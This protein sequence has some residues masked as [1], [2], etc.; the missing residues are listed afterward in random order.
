MLSLRPRR[1]FV[2]RITNGTMPT[3]FH[4]PAAKPFWVLYIILAVLA[5][6]LALPPAWHPLPS[7][8]AFF[9]REK[10]R[11]V[12]IPDAADVQSGIVQT[13]RKLASPVADPASTA[14]KKRH[15]CESKPFLRQGF[16]T[17]PCISKNRHA[18]ERFASAVSRLQTQGGLVRIG[19]FTDSIG[20]GDKITSTLREQFQRRFGDGGPGYV[21]V[22]PLR[23]WHY[24]SRVQLLLS[25]GWTPYCFIGH[26][27]SDRRYGFG[28]IGIGHRGTG[29][30]VRLR[31]KDGGTFRAAQIHFLHHPEGGIF[32]IKAGG[33]TVR[34]IDTRGEKYKEGYVRVSFDSAS[35]LELE[36][37]SGGLVR[38]NAVFLENPGPGVVLDAVS[39]TGARFENWYLMP[40]GHLQAEMAARAPDLLLFH[41]GLNESDTDVEADYKDRVAG[42]MQLVQKAAPASCIIV[43]PSDKV[44]KHNGQ[45]RTLP[46]IRKIA[47]LQEQAAFQA[48]CAFFDTLEAMGGETA[49]VK[50]YE[51]NPRLAMGDLTHITSE[52]AQLLGN[53]MYRDILA[54]LVEP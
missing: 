43:G 3:G 41:F 13:E 36:T 11:P 1:V 25:Q 50:W 7:W 14:T 35:V 28:G 4:F 51:H 9:I 30:T 32:R 34:D 21:S 47:Q 38:I 12:Q 52:G 40:Q 44:Q 6:S 39:L 17:V 19:Y 54:V 20:S 10:A 23:P 31:A 8:R 33:A 37:V 24:H 45:W 15:P 26:P 53:V 18:L 5:A 29:N 46:V 49:I 48:G 2:T 42:F 16:L 27:S 22:Y